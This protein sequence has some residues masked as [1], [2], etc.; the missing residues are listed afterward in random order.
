MRWIIFLLIYA[1]IDVY[2]YQAFRP[3][4]WHKRFKYVY[5]LISIAVIANFLYFWWQ[6]AE[7][8]VL[9]GG[10]S[11]AFGALLAFLVGKSILIVFVFGEDIFRFTTAFFRFLFVKKKSFHLPSRRKFLSTVSLG[12][13]SIPFLSLFYGMYWG[14]YNFRVIKHKLGFPD[15]PK[16]FDGYR[17]LHI[18]DI[19]SGSF[20]DKEEVQQA[21]EMIN[22]QNADVVMFT[23]DLVNNRADEMEGWKN[24]FGA[25]RAKDG[26]FSVFGNHDYGDYYNW[27]STEAKANNLEQL[28][29]V[30]RELGWDLL[31]NEHRF[32]EKNGEKIAVVGVENW[33]SG[34]FVQKGDLDLAAEGLQ[35]DEFKVLLSH[36]PSYWKEKI[37]TD[38]KNYQL[39]LSGHTHGMQFGVEIPGWFKWSPI[40]YRY[41]YWAG[42][43]KEHGRYINVNRGLGYLGYP[44]R[45]GI[46]PEITVV[47][48]K[49]V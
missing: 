40:Q 6:P 14:K 48:L 26:V 3:Q 31:L 4:K 44:G 46:W 34:G 12:I 38:Q 42:V 17:I 10:R 49:K 1:L 39:T 41:T 47:E 24:I 30:H 8:R 9:S 18:S 11:Y 36:D 2:A 25:I 29:R 16:A 5:F 45:V 7:G 33:G 32:I 27:P 21:V 15:L 20:D 37:K 35:E 19:H 28:K 13:A 23:G 43:Y 22:A